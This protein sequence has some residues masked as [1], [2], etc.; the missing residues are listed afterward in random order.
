LSLLEFVLQIVHIVVFIDIAR[1][2]AEADTINNRCVVERVGH[3]SVLFDQERLEHPAVGVETGG[4]KD[5]VL[6]SQK[7]A[8][9]LFQRFV[10]G[11]GA[12]DEPHRRHAEAIGGQRRLCLRHQPRVVG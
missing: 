6:G 9:P 12:A 5:G 7:C 11:L 2:F 10:N 8:Q 3:Y 1:R 4:V